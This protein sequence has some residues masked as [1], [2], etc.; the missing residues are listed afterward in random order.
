[1]IYYPRRVICVDDDTQRPGITK[2]KIYTLLKA[3]GNRDEFPVLIDDHGIETGY[4]SV[5]RFQD[6]IQ[7]KPFSLARVEVK[8]S[9]GEEVFP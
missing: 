1:M 7:N 9:A 4:Y 8:A 3:S 2:G 5:G 6:F